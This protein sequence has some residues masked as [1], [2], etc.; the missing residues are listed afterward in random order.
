[1]YFVFDPYYEENTNSGSAAVHIMEEP[2]HALLNAEKS[3]T[4]THG[5][6]GLTASKVLTPFPS[7]A[8]LTKAGLDDPFVRVTTVM[9]DGKEM[10]FRLGDSYTDE[11][12]NKMYYGYFDGVDC[13]YGFS[14][15]DTVYDNVLPEDVTSKV[16]V[17]TYVWEIGT[18]NY[19]TDSV[20]LDF[21]VIGESA[22]DAVIKLN[23]ERYENVERYRLLYTYLLKT[24]AEDL[25]LEEPDDVGEELASVYLD[26]QDHARSY[27]IKF[28]DAGGLK[29][30]IEID[31]QIRFRCRKSYVTTLIENMEIFGN[32]DQDFTMTW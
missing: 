30:Y 1:M 31:G 12:G 13:I 3:G 7:E 26:R 8:D 32:E 4:T 14:P 18:L 29:A 21:D 9:S 24:A 5:L 22:D 28:Y 6:F 25:V 20:K 27:D 10:V 19:E 17:D 2:I 11:D 16:V 23:G 15:D